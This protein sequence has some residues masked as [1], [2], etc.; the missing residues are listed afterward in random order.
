MS[1]NSILYSED[2]NFIDC[3]MCYARC[4]VMDWDLTWI[5]DDTAICFICATKINQYYKL[6]NKYNIL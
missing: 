3:E 4:L 2:D 6:I 5:D 1:E